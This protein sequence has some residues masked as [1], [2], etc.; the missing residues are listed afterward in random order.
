MKKKIIVIT[1][2]KDAGLFHARWIQLLLAD[3]V[4]VTACTVTE[5]QKQAGI[6]ADLYCITTDA[7]EQIPDLYELTVPGSEVVHFFVTFSQKTVEKLNSIPVGTKALFVNIS[8]K[9]A[10]ECITSLNQLGVNHICFIPYYPGMDE[11]LAEGV[12]I[13]VTPDEERYVPTCIKDVINIGQ[14]QMDCNTL[15]EVLLKLGVSD[16]LES[17]QIKTYLESIMSNS[18]SFDELLGRSL[19]L[20]SSFQSLIDALDIGIIGTNEQGNIFVYNKKAE[21]VIGFSLDYAIGRKADEIVPFLPFEECRE[22]GQIVK[23]RLIRFKWIPINTSIVSVVRKRKHIGAIAMLQHFREEEER[24]HKVR[25]QLLDKGHKAKYTFDDIVGESAAICR[26]KEIAKKMAK[27]KASILI[28][29]ESGTG[30]E[31]FAHA[32]HNASERKQF[33]FIAINCAALPENLLESELFGYVDG[34]FTGAK[35]GGKM[36]LFEF[37]HMGTFFLDEVEG[38]SPMLQIKLLR[39][40]QEHEVMRIGD[41]RLIN[42]DVRIIAAS[43]EKL[44]QLVCEG[45]FRR[46]LYYRLNTLPVNLPPLRERREDIMPL[47]WDIQ[48]KMGVSYDISPEAEKELLFHE[49]NGNVRELRNYAEYFSYLDKKIIEPEDLPPGFYQKLHIVPNN[50]QTEIKNEKSGLPELAGKQYDEWI[51]ILETLAQGKKE[52]ITAGRTSLVEEAKK[53][54][55]LLSEYEVREILASM[56]QQGWVKIRRGRGG[57]RITQKG[58]DILQ[59]ENG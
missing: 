59:K 15:V 12:S 14:R 6:P 58:E 24:Q 25:A 47:F 45:K 41:N 40:L 46:D 42:V 21:K 23:D 19:R 56:E 32:I 54:H 29:G 10:Q 9:M 37:A 3:R 8:E 11:A 34:A 26:V 20:E 30:K 39:V 31:L 35:K 49:W 55:I 57:T 17:P 7:V 5:F 36:G 28:T 1:C 22:N 4:T 27:T 16:M 48:R 38:M 50:F 43:N 44:E 2:D 13:A 51:F 53:K 52:G 18:Y 33:P